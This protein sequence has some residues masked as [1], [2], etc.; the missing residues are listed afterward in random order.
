MFYKP[1]RSNLVSDALSR[2]FSEEEPSLLEI[3]SPIPY[4]VHQLQQYYTSSKNGKNLVH[5]K[6]KNKDEHN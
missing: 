4:L 2:K 1:G 6:V 3:S 5:E